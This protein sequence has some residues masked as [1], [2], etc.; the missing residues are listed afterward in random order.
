MVDYLMLYTVPA[1]LGFA[2]REAM[3][4]ASDDDDRD[5]WVEMA[6][7]QASY[8]LGTLLITR[9]LSGAVQGYGYEGPA[10][11]RALSSAA[12]LMKQVEQGELDPA[13]WRTLNDTAG[14]VFHYPSG[15]IKRSVEGFAA[16]IEGKTSN[17][18]ALISGA[19][20]R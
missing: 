1:A 13:F 12:K 8:M 16:I 7:E 4:P 11:A 6:K 15:Q 18:G 10:G 3:R 14:A 19:P 20:R 5:L 2:V 17:P 9:E